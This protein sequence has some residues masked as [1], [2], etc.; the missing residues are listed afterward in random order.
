MKYYDLDQEE[1][2]LLAAYDA[3]KLKPAKNQAK[4]RKILVEAAKNTLA[5]KQN[6]NLRLAQKTLIKLKAKAAE[7]G[8]PYQTL[9]ASILHRYATGNL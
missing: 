4:W 7:Q 5:K 1:R 8:L 6:V 3:G 9:A 2:E